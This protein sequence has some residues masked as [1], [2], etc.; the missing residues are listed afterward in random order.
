MKRSLAILGFVLLFLFV[1]S[2]ISLAQEQYGNIRGKV[3]DSDKE[4]LPGVTITLECPLY[5]AR[6]VM[7]TSG[8]VFR[9]LNLPSGTYSFKCELSGFK[10]YVEENIIIRVGNNFDFPVILEQSTLEEDVT[11]VATSP[12]VDAKKTGAAYN[13]TEVMLQEIP[14]A[15]DPWVILN[16]IPGIDVWQENVGGSTSG[17]QA[18]WSGKGSSTSYSGN[19][20]M[21]GINITSMH[22]T[23]ATDRYFDFDSFEEIQ[24]V[25]TGQNPTIKTGGVSINMV[26]RR[27]G[28]K[29]EFLG[30]FFFTN[31]KLQ[32]DNRT[33][34]LIDLDYVGNQINQL[35][36]YGFQAGGPIIKDRLWFW[37]GYGVQDIRLF[38]IDGYPADTKIESINT[39]L[40]FQLSRKDRGEV[41]FLYTDKTQFNRFVGP[42]RPPETT[43]NIVGN[44][45]P[46]VKMEYERLFSDT[47]L[48]TL[49]LAYSWGW[50]GFDPNGGMDTQAG[51]DIFTGMHFGTAQ[52]QRVRRPSYNAQLYGNYF[53]EDFLGG[54]HEMKFGLEY[55]LTPQWGENIWPGG[56][57]RFFRNG[58]P[59]RAYILRTV[60]DTAKDRFSVYFND[61]YSRGRL[62]INLGL[63]LDRENSWA[64]EIEVPL[65]PV[66]PA[67]MPAYTH[68]AIDPG[69]F[70]WTLQPRLGMTY[71][72]TGDG[73]TILRANIGRYSF[74]PPNLGSLL[75]TSGSNSAL[76]YWDDLDGDTLVSTEE[77][78][79]Y[80]YEGLLSYS[81]YDIFN[82]TS[83]DS[84]Y[85]IN[86]NLKLDLTDELFIGLEREIF[87]D[88]SV[89]ANVTIRKNYRDRWSVAFNR[90]TGQKDNQDDWEGP[91]QGSVTVDGK[92]FDYEY[93][94]PNTHRFD[95]PNSI[96]ENRPD[97]HKN[98]TSL[99]VIATK[100]LSH[101]WMMNA[102]FSIQKNSDHY[103][104]RGYIDPTNIKFMED[105]DNLG[106]P[107]WMAKINFLY[108]LPWGFNFS[109]FAHIRDGWAWWQYVRVYP[110][111]LAAKG[112]GGGVDIYVEK[113]GETRLP[114]FYNVDL[115]LSKDFILGRYGRL[116]IQVDTFNIFNFD[117]DIWRTNRLNSPYYNEIEEILNPR[118]I[119]LGVR[120]RF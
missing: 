118:V 2:G 105:A 13:V 44:G 89:A 28:N 93:W 58:E 92:T 73:K 112:L 10:T 33:Q 65:N 21:D 37:L 67:I 12:I 74:W 91:F 108:Q 52:Y 102:S 4:P 101:R 50:F 22:A 45:A 62:T 78:V 59:F 94:A 42:R 38:S 1:S 29:F 53:L 7:S 61:S 69:V 99:E 20:V 87:K 43:Y 41:A 106:D 84:P 23:G 8:G 79:G 98:H 3:T 71:D 96:L 31:D 63:R 97:F 120:Y 116:T 15:R 47:F 32:G 85:E 81:G 54:G 110:P 60:T 26:T 95:L 113:L 36:D 80:P 35:T 115:S 86:P 51:F 49:K 72:I 48:M 64:N 82:P 46:L 39:K 109:G 30:R 14:S 117:H 114:N 75:A 77:L 56:V 83:T 70:F 40:N 107:R 34:E 16:L 24:V 27:G 5:G 68:P 25:T 100:R 119:R 6:S 9:F 90:E 76:Y 57:R 103:G 111:E 11:V 88:F 17:E 66:A 18:W 104:E 19:Y 55:R